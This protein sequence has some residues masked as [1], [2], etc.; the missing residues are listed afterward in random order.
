MAIDRTKLRWNGWGLIDAPDLLGDRAD[1]V[2]AWMSEVCGISP[3]PET[4]A[5][6]LEQIELSE[7]ALDADTL[8]ALGEILSPDRV[9][10]DNTERAFHCR[11]RSYPDLLALRSGRIGAAPDAIVYPETEDEVLA[12][13]KF[14]EAEHIALVPYGGGSSVVGGVNAV[15]TSN[16]RG[17]VTID[18][19]HMDAILE[20]DE[21]GLT[22]RI[23]PG[24]YGPALEEKLQAKGYTLGHYPQ[25][26]EFSTL[27]GW[28]AHRGAGQQSNKYGKAE[29]W[30]IAARLATPQG[31]WSTESYPAS[32]AGPRLGSMVVGSEGTLG[33][34]TEATVR[35]HRV[36]E[37]KDY[38]GYL[39]QEFSKG[40]AAAREIAQAGIPV[41]MVRLSDADETFF[42]AAMQ[43]VGAEGPPKVRFCL[44]LVGIEGDA[45][46][47]EAATKAS[48]AIIERNGG[49]HAGES[50]GEKWYAAR[51]A[52]PYLRD[53]MAD[54][55]I[56]IDTVETSTS[57]ANIMSLHG[58]TIDAI[59]G[60]IAANPGGGSGGGDRSRDGVVM[61]HLSHSYRDGASL[62]F[63]FAFARDLNAELD[64]W[65]AIKK[66]ASDAILAGG[67]TISH[68]HGVGTDHLPWMEADKGALAVSLLKAV[69]D[70]IDPENVLNPGKLIG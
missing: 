46:A 24:I 45:T 14:A 8:G 39:F 51:F 68:H 27:G 59:R 41:A 65:H 53:P 57:W 11:G 62:Y 16:Q 4:P 18:M 21:L 35:L 52:S 9:R 6:D 54:R 40:V 37:T 17:V 30:F 61:A 48:R 13:I 26:F 25:S 20:I 69:K 70:R 44:M 19:T 43:M 15:R 58:V 22:A 56:G 67:G 7:I 63:T 33:I 23:Q 12:L 49:M 29:K 28:I 2:W 5:C 1:A 36:P 38:R 32:A 50:F 42:Y 66:A 60:A 31:I 34:I 64:Q 3:L 47:V 55:G 10:T